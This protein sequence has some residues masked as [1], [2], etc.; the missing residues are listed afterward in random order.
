MIFL[1]HE[2]TPPCIVIVR[3]RWRHHDY[4]MFDRRSRHYDWRRRRFLFKRTDTLALTRWSWRLTF[5]AVR[6]VSDRVE[7]ILKR[8]VEA[9]H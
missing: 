2:S 4:A 7:C 8:V 3:W 6:V 1:P 9:A 5:F